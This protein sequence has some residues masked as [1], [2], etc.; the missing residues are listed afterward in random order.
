[1]P[2]PEEE[3][4]GNTPGASSSTTTRDK[5]YRRKQNPTPADTERGN[6][7]LATVNAIAAERSRTRGRSPGPPPAPT[8]AP[9]PAPAPKAKAKAT[10]KAK[11]TAK[12]K[13]KA[14]VRSR[15]VGGSLAPILEVAEGPTPDSVPIT[16]GQRPF[17]KGEGHVLPSTNPRK[18]SKGRKKKVHGLEAPAVE[19]HDL[20][21]DPYVNKPKLQLPEKSRK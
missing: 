19:Y 9:P 6:I 13:A 21:D 5:R 20:K 10:P 14:S 4:R 17:V 11:A 8:P 18:P 15:S 1:M 2:I 7:G 3:T 16:D 12:P